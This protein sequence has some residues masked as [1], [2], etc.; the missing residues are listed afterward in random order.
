MHKQTIIDW[1]YSDFDGYNEKKE[2]AALRKLLK[3]S[4]SFEDAKF[5][6][7]AAFNCNFP[8]F[9]VLKGALLLAS[10]SAKTKA[11]RRSLPG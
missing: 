6:Y 9:D 2:L 3:A 5:T 7:D 1:C 10:E 11:C 8:C 4:N